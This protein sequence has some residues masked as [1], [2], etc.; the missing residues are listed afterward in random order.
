[1]A[2]FRAPDPEPQKPPVRVSIR[3]ANGV[4]PAWQAARLEL[5]EVLPVN[6]RKI[7]EFLA[8]NEFEFEGID[9]LADPERAKRR[10]RALRDGFNK[11]GRFMTSIGVLR[12]EDVR[13]E[14]FTEIG[15]AKRPRKEE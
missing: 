3:A 4:A 7:D 1:M 2:S 5:L 13:P 6:N 12:P 9:L 8:V 15:T 14:L 11:L 10:A